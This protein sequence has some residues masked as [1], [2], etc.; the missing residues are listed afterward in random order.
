M[1]ALHFNSNTCWC[2]HTQTTSNS[3]HMA[4]GLNKLAGYLVMGAY[5]LTDEEFVVVVLDIGNV[6]PSDHMVTAF[7]KGLRRSHDSSACSD[8]LGTSDGVLTSDVW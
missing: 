3:I 1:A 2:I 8:W 4:G 7:L 5:L 6:S